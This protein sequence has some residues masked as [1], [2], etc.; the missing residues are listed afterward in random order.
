MFCIR[1]S[2]YKLASFIYVRLKERKFVNSLSLNSVL[3]DY[4]CRTGFILCPGSSVNDLSSGHFEEISRGISVGI[5]SWAL[6]SFNPDFLLYEP[7]RNNPRDTLACLEAILDLSQH[8][9]VLIPHQGLWASEIFSLLMPPDRLLYY[10]PTPMGRSQGSAM[11]AFKNMF[12][13]RSLVREKSIFGTG[14]SVIRAI[15]LLAHTGCEN[16]VLVGL[17]FT[18]EYFSPEKKPSLLEN[19]ANLN[20]VDSAK[21]LGLLPFL[22]EYAL[23][24]QDS[25]TVPRLYGYMD[26]N[27]PLSGIL[28]SYNFGVDSF[29]RN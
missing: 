8:T 18:D 4:G 6:H 11:R 21:R 16:I 5:N 9:K 15:S 12:K 10:V 23:V 3:D 27:N 25:G 26:E 17:D 7:S 20:G 24:M 28:P 2:A 13:Q 19:K 1:D 29:A 22:R 14:A